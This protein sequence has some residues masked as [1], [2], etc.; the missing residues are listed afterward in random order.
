M[1]TKINDRRAYLDAGAP[2]LPPG[3]LVDQFGR[4][5]ASYGSFYEAG[6]RFRNGDYNRAYW[7]DGARDTE[8]LLDVSTWRDMMTAARFLFANEPM[9]RGAVLE[10]AA[11]SFPLTPQYMGKD[12]KWGDQIGE[13][14]LY[15]WKANKTVRGA[16]F[17]NDTCA[18]LRLIARK[19]DG[20]CPW[21]LTHDDDD[22]FPRIQYLRAHRIGDRMMPTRGELTE[23]PYRGYRIHNGVVV[24]RQGRPIAYHVLGDSEATDRFI[25]A[26]SLFLTYNPDA[27]DESRGKSELLASVPSFADIKRLRGYEMRAQQLFASLCLMEDTE[28]GGADDSATKALTRP[29]DSTDTASAPTGLVTR[30]Y[31]KGMHLYFKALSGAGLK[32]FRSDRPSRDSQDWEDKMVTAAIYGSGWDPNFALMIEQPGGALARIMVEKIRRTIELNQRL[33]SCAQRI[34]DSY[35]LASAIAKKLIPPPS[36]GDVMSWEYQ[37]PPRITADSGNEFKA[38]LQAYKEGAISLKK[39][40]SEQGGSWEVHRQQKK[41]EAVNLALHARELQQMFPEMSFR[42]WLNFLEQRNIN[43][44]SSDSDKEPPEDEPPPK[45]NPQDED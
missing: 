35:A 1:P 39:V 24:N 36:D 11:L 40:I 3:T 43:P 5:M 16:A 8:E 19:I 31:E 20:D 41:D 6:D 17:P 34:E 23:G 42:E 4:P 18:R 13:P 45:P 30:S 29:A 7:Q 32:A 28:S 15:R 14:W 38:Q 21:I 22:E 2:Q 33:E 37:G 10:Q 44:S 26:G 27:F 9:V 25:P 12:R